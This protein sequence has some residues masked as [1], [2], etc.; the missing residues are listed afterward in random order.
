V[1][2]EIYSTYFKKINK[3]VGLGLRA[4]RYDPTGRVQSTLEM[5]IEYLWKSLRSVI[6]KIERIP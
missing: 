5:N 2:Y 3:K 4:P 6:V 1:G